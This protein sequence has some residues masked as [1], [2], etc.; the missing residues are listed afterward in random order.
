VY[1]LPGYAKYYCKIRNKIFKLDTSHDWWRYPI[2]FL[3]IMDAEALDEFNLDSSPDFYLTWDVLRQGF[4]KISQNDCYKFA[5][6][7]SNEYKKL[8]L[9]FQNYFDSTRSL[10]NLEASSCVLYIRGGDKTILET[11]KGPEDLLRKDIV[12]IQDLNV[13]I[14]VLSDDFRLAESL[15]KKYGNNTTLNLTKNIFLGYHYGLS[16]TIEDFFAIIENYLILSSCSYS[17]SCPSSNLINSA[18]W[19]NMKL[20]KHFPLHSI[21]TYRYLYL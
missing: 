6:F 21:P 12:A 5:A 9:N 20:N 8:R 18:N 7:K 15:C 11:I 3:D 14:Y 10:I 19:S 2:P 1:F 16:N 13:P 17:I 4:N